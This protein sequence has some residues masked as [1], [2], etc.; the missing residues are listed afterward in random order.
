MDE[1]EERKYVSKQE[2]RDYLWSRGDLS[3]QLDELQLSMFNT[4]CSN[5]LSSKKICILSSRQIGKSYF[6]LIFAIHFLLKNPGK[7]ARVI[8]PTR[9]ACEEIV[10]DNLAK[11][12][13]TAPEGFIKKSAAHNCYDIYNRSSLRLGAGERQYADKNR[14]G[15]A[16]LII[17]E[18]CG[19]LSADELSY[20]MRSVINAQLLRSKGHE[21]F[22][23]S[24]STDPEHILHTEILPEAEA[25]GTA[26][27]YNV[28]ESPSISDESIAEAIKRSGCKIGSNSQSD[29]IYFV[30]RVREID[31]KNQVEF[32][33]LAESEGHFISEDFYREYMAYI[34]RAASLVCIPR[35]VE[36]H[37]VMEYMPPL[38]PWQITIDW[39]G[40]RDLTVALLHLYDTQSDLDI[41]YDEK[42]WDANT[43]TSRIVQDLRDWEDDYHIQH[44]RADVPG[45]TRVDLMNEHNYEVSS[46]EKSDW[47][48]GVTGM[49]SRI[50]QEKV[51]IH[52]R[53]AFL[54][55]SIKGGIFNKQKTDFERTRELG[56]CDALAALMYALRG[57][58]VYGLNLPKI[59]SHSMANQYIDVRKQTDNMTALAAGKAFGKFKY[60]RLPMR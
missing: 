5:Y 48:A 19:F 16:S 27:C 8:A 12:L 38:L 42:M 36:K 20:L 17:Y 45:Q 29:L 57:S 22:V 44:R 47:L 56:H 23:S 2:M 7:I 9:Y 32:E 30:D 54:I 50:A 59:N 28:F 1:P 46:P 58:N 14:G 52:P 35:F 26:F 31:H 55:R 43:P 3:W 49:A 34:V 24:P 11:I 33:K 39:G 4:I 53:C 15:N 18:E 60:G 13:L 10:Q 25:A 41:V 37:I 51:R 6:S 40:V 21:I